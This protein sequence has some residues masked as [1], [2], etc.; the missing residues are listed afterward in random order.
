M[1]G[2]YIIDQECQYYNLNAKVYALDYHQDLPIPVK[3][4]IP[5]KELKSTLKELSMI[6]KDQ[7]VSA[8]NPKSLEAFIE[9]KVIEQLM[10]AQEIDAFFKQYRML[11]IVSI[12]INAIVLLIIVK[13]TGILSNV[14]I[15]G[16]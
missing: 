15:P 1:G 11:L 13:A 9:S 5:V 6:D 10:K 4:E 7:L 3:R 16:M 2:I 14:K 12:I 8:V